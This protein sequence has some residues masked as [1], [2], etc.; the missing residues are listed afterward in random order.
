MGIG[1]KAQSSKWP[2]DKAKR[3]VIKW[4]GE[5]MT[6]RQAMER[7]ER[8]E[9][10]YKVWRDRDK[11]FAMACD[12]ARGMNADV[13]A[14]NRAN[15]P[16]F[17]EFSAKYL[18]QPLFRHQLQWI[19]VLEGRKP[20]D[21]HERQVY[22]PGDKNYVL[23]NTPPNHAKSTTITTN[24]VTYRICADPNVRIL[25]ISKT[26]EMAKKFIYGVK[27]RLT[28]V[29]YR[30]LQRDFSPAG[31]FKGEES[32]WQAAM[33]Y[34][35]ADVK[36]KGEKDP[37]IQGLGMGQQIYG[38]RA[39][40][41]IVDDAVVLSNAHEYDKQIEWLNLEV[42]TRL[43]PIGK[44]LVVGTR[45]ASQDMYR[46]L[47]STER[48]PDGQ[49]PW[50]YLTQ[51]AVLEYSDTPEGWVTL[52]PAA[53]D[54]F[55][56][57]DAV[58][59]PTGMY[60]RWT[61]PRLAQMRQRVGNRIWSLAYMQ[62]NVS[63]DSVF[64]EKAVLAAVNKS[65]R[66]GLLLKDHKGHRRNGMEGLYVIG[67]LDPAIA[68]FAGVTVVGVDRENQ[69]RYLL[70]VINQK[71]PTPAWVRDKLL[72]LTDYYGIH[73]WRIEEN[74]YQRAIVLDRELRDGLATRGCIL[75]PHHTG[76]NKVD[77]EFGVASMAPLF[78]EGMIEL[79][80]TAGDEAVKQLIEQLITWEPGIKASKLTQDLVM[81][82]WFCEIRAREIAAKALGGA[83]Q[84]MNNRF[85]N[86]RDKS[87]RFVASRADL[88]GMHSG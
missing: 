53:Q 83:H 77:P 74:A 18:H 71:A 16:S 65:R 73:E 63:Q 52:W 30:D 69:K 29:R 68:G 49:C 78:T 82:L 76:R 46:E 54:P 86:K 24:Y 79:P 9:A 14:A 6:I 51:P 61:G 7:C 2:I 27:S 41:I 17:E 26:Q 19:D 36:D 56:G 64:P 58:A 55:P 39:D 66:G 80:T 88:I 40:L 8:S 42:M 37:T 60:P 23:I 35:A 25:V 70:K 48:Y 21:L 57:D 59:N 84:F 50:T 72:E 34:L 85:A 22:E 20:R 43:D 10:T 67:G 28:G 4:L 87:R 31:G 32:V 62:D 47:R 44:L 38:A 75:T 12:S 5:G 81:S 11:D 1:R 3:F 13:I 45:V 15:M 33:V